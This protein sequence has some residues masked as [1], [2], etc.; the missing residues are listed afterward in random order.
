MRREWTG[1]WLLK[2]LPQ[3]NTYHFAHILFTKA[4]HWALTNY[5]AG[6]RE[7]TSC[8]RR[9]KGMC[10][11]QYW[12]VP[13]TVNQDAGT[14]NREINLV[15]WY[16][17]YTIFQC[18]NI[19][20]EH[21]DC[22]HCFLCDYKQRCL[23]VYIGNSFFKEYIRHI[24]VYVYTHTHTNGIVLVAMSY[25][26]GRMSALS[27]LMYWAEIFNLF[28]YVICAF[29]FMFINSFLPQIYKDIVLYFLLKVFR[30]CFSCLV[31]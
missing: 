17:V 18:I 12:H 13:S 21:S 23:L 7:L 29:P 14:F 6:G 9:R 27:W 26:T 24:H 31:L 5:K 8:V 11:Q 16:K 25:L 19:P 30:F 22:Y 1:Q 15:H 4:S 28:L 2:F 3:S 20:K 10:G